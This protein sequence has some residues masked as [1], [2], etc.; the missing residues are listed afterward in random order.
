M[1]PAQS[2]PPTPPPPPSGSSEDL[3]HLRLL[4]IFH[5]VVGALVALFACIPLI[6]VAMGAF[7]IA[8]GLGGGGE[9]A[10]VAGAVGCLIMAFAAFFVAAGWTLAVCI[11]LAGRYLSRREKYTFCLVVAAIACLF[12]PIGTVLGVFTIIVLM[13]PSV[14]TLFGRPG[15]PPAAAG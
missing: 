11:L 15:P 5:Y 9:D 6:H 1:E 2:P 7:F 3:E 12:A 14:K 10:A 8:G 13:R 4:S